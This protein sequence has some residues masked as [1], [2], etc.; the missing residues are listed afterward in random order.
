MKFGKLYQIMKIM[1]LLILEECGYCNN[2]HKDPNGY[3]WKYE[4]KK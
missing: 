2:L 3:I 4:T 1:K